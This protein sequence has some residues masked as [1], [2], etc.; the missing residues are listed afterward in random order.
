M[1]SLGGTGDCEGGV[2]FALFFCG[3]PR[4]QA[5]FDGRGGFFAVEAVAGPGLLILREMEDL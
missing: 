2:V 4:A 5:D 3:G 1:G